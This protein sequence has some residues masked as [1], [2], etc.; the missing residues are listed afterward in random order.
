MMALALIVVVRWKE[1]VRVHNRWT[2]N[3]DTYVHE[4]NRIL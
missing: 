2:W 4:I 3:L 1:V